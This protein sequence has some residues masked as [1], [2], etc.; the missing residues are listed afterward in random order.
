MRDQERRYGLGGWSETRYV[1]RLV[2]V[3]VESGPKLWQVEPLG[4]DTTLEV[5]F[6]VLSMMKKRGVGCWGLLSI[7]ELADAKMRMKLGEPIQ[8]QQVWVYH[9]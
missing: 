6:E 4:E 3:S 7:G 8:L 9:V 2:E 5:E 1:S